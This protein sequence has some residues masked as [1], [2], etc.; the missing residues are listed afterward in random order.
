MSDFKICPE[1][2]MLLSITRFPIT[3]PKKY[4]KNTCRSCLHKELRKNANYV[5]SRMLT[6]AEARCKN[7]NRDAYA[8]YGGRGIQFLLTTEDKKTFKEMFRDEVQKLIDADKTPSIDRINFDGNYE[9]G[10]VRVVE[11]R[12]NTEEARKHITDNWREQRAAATHKKCRKCKETKP[13]NEMK[14]KKHYSDGTTSYEAICSICF[15]KTC[16]LNGWG[17]RIPRRPEDCQ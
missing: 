10:N 17:G 16:Q 3:G 2:G 15:R 8:R 9:L 14:V 5:I 4:R 7:P 11:H 1:C 12:V 6:Q 13:L